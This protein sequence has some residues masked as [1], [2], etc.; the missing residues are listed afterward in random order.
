MN[1][2]HSYRIGA[3]IHGVISR[4][5]EASVLGLTSKGIYLLVNKTHVAFITTEPYAS[6]L[7]I[8]IE[9]FHDYKK[10]LVIKDSAEIKRGDILF[11]RTGFKIINSKSTTWKP[12][13]LPSTSSNF[14]SIM[15]RSD[16]LISNLQ[17]EIR[18][19]QFLEAAS[20]IRRANIQSRSNELSQNILLIHHALSDNNTNGLIKVVLP[21]IG[22]GQGL[23]PS[24]DDFISGMILIQ[25]RWNSIIKTGID[26][27]KINNAVIKRA[28]TAT[29]SL[30][31]NLIE[32]A[33]K[34]QADERII[35]VLD[36]LITGNKLSDDLLKDLLSY[37]NTSGMEILVGIITGISDI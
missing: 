37:G 22:R 29:S 34:G 30:S 23:T 24:G 31:A 18:K 10:Y 33:A 9:D 17:P 6:P 14:P 2:I 13:D 32:L 5:E 19:S 11:E 21:F 27:K 8:N 3:H 16:Q 28:K 25:N 36:Y 15:K 20:M 35:N 4:S 1:S 7:T 12:P 26:L